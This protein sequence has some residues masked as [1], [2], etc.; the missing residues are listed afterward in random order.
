VLEYRTFDR[1]VDPLVKF[2][3]KMGYIITDAGK[4]GLEEELEDAVRKV[5]AMLSSP[6][7]RS[8]QQGV[9]TILKWRI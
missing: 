5:E 2:F 4:Y 6:P 1:V 7:A 8:Q 9:V 3:R